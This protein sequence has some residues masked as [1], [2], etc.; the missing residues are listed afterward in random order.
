MAAIK[1]DI[2]E[3]RKFG[4]KNKLVWARKYYVSVVQKPV[5]VLDIVSPILQII[6]FR[7]L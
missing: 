4:N 2:K 6:L 3:T 7:Y 1:G 5:T